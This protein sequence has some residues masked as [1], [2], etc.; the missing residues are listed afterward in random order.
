MVDGRFGE[1][2][3]TTEGTEDTEKRGIGGRERKIKDW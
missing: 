2:R 3:F 1:R